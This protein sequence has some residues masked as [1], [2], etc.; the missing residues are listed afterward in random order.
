MSEGDY[1]YSYSILNHS[2]WN[3]EKII[4]IINGEDMQVLKVCAQ[5]IFPYRGVY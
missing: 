1:E 3:T 2:N 4:K 5:L